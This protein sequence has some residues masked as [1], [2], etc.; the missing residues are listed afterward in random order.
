MIEGPKFVDA[1]D[2]VGVGM[3]EEHRIH[4]IQLDRQRLL[5]QVCRGVHQDGFTPF[6]N[7]DRGSGSLISGIGGSTNGTPAADH[8]NAG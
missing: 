8:R 2:M 1:M 3:G 6:L 7:Q 5:P 4:S